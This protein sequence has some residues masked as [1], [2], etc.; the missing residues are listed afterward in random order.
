MVGWLGGWVVGWLGGG[1][2]WLVWLGGCVLCGVGWCVVCGCVV[3]GVWCVVWCVCGVCVVCVCVAGEGGGGGGGTV[4]RTQL[5]LTPPPGIATHE[6]SG[7]HGVHLPELSLCS[8]RD[9]VLRKMLWWWWWWCGPGADDTV[10]PYDI[11]AHAPNYGGRVPVDTTPC[12]VP[13]YRALKNPHQPNSTTES[14]QDHRSQRFLN[15][16]PGKQLNLHNRDI[17]HPARTAT[18]KSPW[19]ANRPDQHNRGIDN[20]KRTA[21]GETLWSAE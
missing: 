2:G 19:S 20:L 21:T 16:A 9:S 5:A 10:Y 7:R 15:R 14:C 12:P 8:A 6:V 13:V 17:D 18:A 3:C 4:E 1:V 11:A